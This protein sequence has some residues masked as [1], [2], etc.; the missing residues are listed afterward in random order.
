M[1]SKNGNRLVSINT[2]KN[3]NIE[4]VKIYAIWQLTVVF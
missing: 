2:H 4:K 3:V 1:W